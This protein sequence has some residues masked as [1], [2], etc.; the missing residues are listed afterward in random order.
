[1]IRISGT[2]PAFTGRIVRTSG[3]Q[4]C[5]FGIGFHASHFPMM[6]GLYADDYVEVFEAVNNDVLLLNS[7]A[8]PPENSEGGLANQI[9]GEFF[10]LEF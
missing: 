2:V 1:M 3:Y 10:P 5:K 7:I 8:E 4:N 9:L 6:K